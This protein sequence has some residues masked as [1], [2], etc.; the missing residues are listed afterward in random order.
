VIDAPPGPACACSGSFAGVFGF[1]LGAA[2]SA[3]MPGSGLCA[4]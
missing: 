2:A 3:A 4:S 1:A